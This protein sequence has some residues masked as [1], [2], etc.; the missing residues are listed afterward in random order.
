[1]G[2]RVVGLGTWDLRRDDT[3]ADP[4][5]RAETAEDAVRAALRG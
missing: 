4:L 5:V 1:M 2:K 3:D